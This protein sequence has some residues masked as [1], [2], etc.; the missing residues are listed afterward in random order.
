MRLLERVAMQKVSQNQ[1]DLPSCNA[2]A[3]AP[4]LRRL[5][6]AFSVVEMTSRFAVCPGVVF[7]GQFSVE[8][9]SSETS[10]D[11]SLPRGGTASLQ[12]EASPGC[13]GSDMVQEKARRRVGRLGRLE[14]A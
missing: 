10:G 8:A 5:R 6:S 14:G 4:R 13:S 7:S 2:G 12:V 3:K 9:S 1:P 11:P